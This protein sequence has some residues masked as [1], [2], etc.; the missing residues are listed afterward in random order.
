MMGLSADVWLGFFLGVIFCVIMAY[1]ADVFFSD[2]RNGSKR[3]IVP[4]DI[5]QFTA[6]EKMI[7]ELR[8]IILSTWNIRSYDH[9]DVR[10]STLTQAMLGSPM[11][12]ASI[13]IAY[14]CNGERCDVTML[15]RN[16]PV[17]N[18]LYANE[19]LHPRYLFTRVIKGDELFVTL[20]DLN[21][22]DLHTYHYDHLR[23]ASETVMDM[24]QAKEASP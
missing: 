23:E 15:D 5:Y 20:Y 21:D 9:V 7:P 8:S 10:I 3:R 16:M 18:E 22:T 2:K 24:G 1:L 17:G 14:A 12:V 19:G 6:C 13:W 11:D 4:A